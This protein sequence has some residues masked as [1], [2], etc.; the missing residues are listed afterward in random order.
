M[1]LAELGIKNGVQ[2]FIN[3]NSYFNKSNSSYSNLQDYSLSKK[4]FLIWLQKLSSKLKIINVFLEH[5]YGL[6]DSDSKFVES[7][8]K[9]I[10]IKQV[11]RVELTHGHQKRDFVYLDDVVKAYMTLIE[12]GRDHNFLFKTFELGTGQGTQFVIL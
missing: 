8:I 12:Y 7:M 6:Y 1:H 11:A 5:I 10:A 9:Q 2:C 3:I 4:S